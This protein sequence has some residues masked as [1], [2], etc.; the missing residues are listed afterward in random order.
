VTTKTVEDFLGWTDL[1]R[2]RLLLVK[3]A[4]R[5]PI[6]ALLLELHV[7]LNH[8]DNIRLAL[9]VVDECLG[10]PHYLKICQPQKGTK[11]TK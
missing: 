3:R 9:E 11:I 6:R 8:T 5:H 1:K 7:I 2:R 4:A 10:V